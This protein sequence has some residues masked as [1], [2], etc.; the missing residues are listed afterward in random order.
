MAKR[1]QNVR[2]KKDNS[3]KTAKQNNAFYCNSA[4]TQ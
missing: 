4:V 2:K 1:Q 3:I